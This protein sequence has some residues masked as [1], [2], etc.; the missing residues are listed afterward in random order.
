M[1]LDYSPVSRK[2]IE[3]FAFNSLLALLDHDGQVTIF[4]I[5]ESCPKTGFEKLTGT[6]Y[7][8]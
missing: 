5:R 3:H 7:N 6:S 4:V 8:N 1:N 2:L